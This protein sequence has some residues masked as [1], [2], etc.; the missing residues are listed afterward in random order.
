[1]ASTG[2][3]WEFV[4]KTNKKSKGNN[5]QNL[6]KNQKKAFVENMPRIEAARKYFTMQ[7]LI[8][9]VQ[10]KFGKCHVSQISL[11]TL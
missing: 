9:L 1:M 2:Q 7:K 11:T 4:G 6:S 8:Q 5:P 3:T 10:I